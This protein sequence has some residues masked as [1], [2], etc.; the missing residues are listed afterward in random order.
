MLEVVVKA[1]ERDNPDEAREVH[2]PGSDDEGITGVLNVGDPVGA[3]LP[4]LGN[5]QLHA[6]P[7][8]EGDSDHEPGDGQ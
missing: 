3:L 8:H 7:R 1:E 2:D 4:G 5:Q 6:A